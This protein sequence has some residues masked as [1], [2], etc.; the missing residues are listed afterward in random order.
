VVLGVMP[1]IVSIFFA[2]AFLWNLNKEHVTSKFLTYFLTVIRD[3]VVLS[4]Q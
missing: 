4:W 3:V 2:F 1:M